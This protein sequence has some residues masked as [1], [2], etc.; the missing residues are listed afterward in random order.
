[1]G[2]RFAGGIRPGVMPWKNRYI[3]NPILTIDRPILFQQPGAAIFIAAFAALA[4]M[5]FARW[6]FA[7]QAWSSPR[8]WSSR[9]ASEAAHRSKYPRRSIRTAGRARRT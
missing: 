6:I 3:G 8:K 1:M 9:H 2:N 7:R 4:A 5:L